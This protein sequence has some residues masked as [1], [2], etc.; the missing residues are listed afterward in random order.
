MRGPATGAATAAAMGD[1][2]EE[3]GEY[4][5]DMKV[6]AGGEWEEGGGGEG[7]RGVVLVR[8]IEGECLRPVG[9]FRAGGS[10]PDLEGIVGS[11][12]RFT[13]NAL[14]PFLDCVTSSALP[15]LAF[16]RIPFCGGGTLKTS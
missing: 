11:E 12:D 2:E 6:L 15:D 5:E 1:A 7:R 16:L 10:V 4:E 9:F 13:K 3:G 14:A 8:G